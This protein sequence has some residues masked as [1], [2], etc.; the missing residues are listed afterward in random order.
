[1]ATS[2]PVGSFPSP[3]EVETPPGCDGWEEMYPYYALFDEKRREADEQRFWF[4]NSMHFPL[5]MPAFDA[6]CI[7]TAYQA[8]GSWQNRVFAVPPAM[9]IDYRCI[10]GYIYI[11]GN[12]VTDPAKIAERAGHFQQRAGHYFQNWDE[13]YAGWRTKMEGLIAELDALEVPSLHELEP[14]DVAFGDQETSF[15]AV[16]DAYRR[17]L[18]LADLMWQNHFEFLL[19]GYG[20]YVTFAELCKAHLPDIPDQHIAQMVAGLDVL[21]FRPDAELR[22]LARLAIETG[23]DAAFVEGRSPA[24]IDAALAESESGRRWLAELEA[25]K[26]PWFHMATGDGLYHYYGSWLDD[27]TIPYASLT[28]H[29][30]ALRAGEDIDPPSGHIAT[31]RERLANEYGALLDDEARKG[32]DELLA[33]S[34]TVFPYVEEHKFLCDYWFLTS[35]WNK[36]RDFGRLLAEHGFLTE[37]EDVFQLSRLEV[38][39]ALDELLLT[40]ATG[41]AA[42][43]PVVLAAD[44][45]EAEG[46]ARAARRLDS[47]AGG[48]RRARGGAGPGADHALGRHDPA[49]PRL[50][51]GDRR[52]LELER[53]PRLAR[54]RRGRGARG[55]ARERDR[56]RAG[57]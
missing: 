31:E 33:L 1:M 53:H 35:W 7:D 13:L 50:G 38:Y 45:G 37:S 6:I 49:S 56:R 55:Q 15:C 20:A 26:D 22:R 18:R 43:R 5:P 16:L 8:L 32:F 57:G 14:D 19:L 17:V 21:L 28:G 51:A 41:G 36:I 12:P 54:H 44:R 29:I 23:V 40:W 34:R 46:A 25:V 27:P 3:Y 24:E 39:S 47:P 48:G 42:A 4:W 9:G 11:S 10:N 52:R 2:S 30:G